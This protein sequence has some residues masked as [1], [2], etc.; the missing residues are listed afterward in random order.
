MIDLIYDLIGL[1]PDLVNLDENV[2]F[3]IAACLLLYC[4]GYVFNFFQ[5]LIGASDIEKTV[6]LWSRSLR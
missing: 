3:C 4:L 2:V 5:K 6:I 1:N